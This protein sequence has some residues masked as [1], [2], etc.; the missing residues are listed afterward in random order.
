MIKSAICIFKARLGGEFCSSDDIMHKGY[1]GSRSMD[2][3]QW[4]LSKKRTRD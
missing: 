1:I 2:Q 3:V 4:G